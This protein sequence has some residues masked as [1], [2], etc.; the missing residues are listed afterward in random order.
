MF[1]N[2]SLNAKETNMVN[3]DLTI[4]LEICQIHNE[5]IAIDQ[6]MAKTLF[7]F[8]LIGV[9]ALCT[10]IYGTTLANGWYIDG[11][12]SDEF[13]I[14][15]LGA[16][17]YSENSNVFK[18]GFIFVGIAL[19]LSASIKTYLIHKC[20]KLSFGIICI[21]ILYIVSSI[22]LIMMAYTPYDVD[23]DAHNLYVSIGIVPIPFT[24]I[25]DAIHWLRYLKYKQIIRIKIICCLLNIYSFTCPILSLI[26]FVINYL[27]IQKA[28]YNPQSQWTAVLLSAASFLVLPIHALYMNSHLKSRAN[29]SGNVENHV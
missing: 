2:S 29:D 25:F 4:D 17:T 22:G 26:F 15:T 27:N 20:W 12:I 23:W 5:T 21:N 3:D 7:I 13:Y 10:A 11:L 9:I 18:I 6:C 16:S 19:I 8:P 24:Q 1:T 28:S 14:S